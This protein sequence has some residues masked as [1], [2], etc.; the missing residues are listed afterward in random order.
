M[1]LKYKP[2]WI[3]KENSILFFKKYD[4][5]LNDSLLFDQ[6]QNLI[7]LCQKWKKMKISHRYYQMKS[8]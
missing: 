3:D 7:C 4:L 1:S 2:L 5:Q 6:S 8:G